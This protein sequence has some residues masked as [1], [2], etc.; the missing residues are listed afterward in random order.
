MIFLKNICEGTC[1]GPS[2]VFLFLLKF[3]K[4]WAIHL[5]ERSPKT[6][7]MKLVKASVIP[8]LTF[9]FFGKIA[10]QN[11]LLDGYVYENANRGYLN[12]VKI[13]AMRLSD[14]TIVGQTVSNQEGHFMLNVDNG[15]YRLSAEKDIFFLKYDTVRVENGKG[16]SKIEMK[17]KPGYLFDVTLAEKRVSEDQAVDAIQG[18]T[19]EIYN[20]TTKKSEMVLKNHPNPG[21]QFTFEQGNIYTIM[22]RKNGYLTRRIEANVAVEGCILCIDGVN[23][24]RP[25]MTENLTE[26]NS[27]GTLL[28]NLDMDKADMGRK[29]ELKNIY[30]DYDKWFIRKEAAKEL[31]KAVTLLKDNPS[32]KVELGSHTDS[33]G[34]TAYN[35]TLS[36]KRAESAVAYIVEHG[37]LQEKITAKGY[38]ESQL[39]NNCG[40][41][42]KC[43]EAEHQ[44]N[45]RT[46]LKITGVLDDPRLFVENQPSLEQIIREEEF[47]KS[48]KALSSEK[49]VKIT[50]KPAKS[51]KPAKPTKDKAQKTEVEMPSKPI[52]MGEI[53]VKTEAIDPNS[54]EKKVVSE[55]PAMAVIEEKTTVGASVNIGSLP[56]NFTG[57]GVEVL[58]SDLPIGGDH[59]VFTNFNKVFVQKDGEAMFNYFIGISND[60]ASSRNW[61]L[62]DAIKKFPDA[63]LVSFAEG[64]KD[65]IK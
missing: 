51:T 15:D 25:G 49:E 17:R 40:D 4:K 1:A 47:D 13:T 12:Q 43:S 33:R 60:L 5:P 41:G 58:R 28:A 20:K 18:A 65:Y 50:E 57:F 24:L 14:N 46:E 11:A 27:M 9:L 39:F 55:T 48:L 3:V 29:I 7:F 62:S 6:Y 53:V 26:G 34:S 44:L 21:F 19:I 38:G 59:P 22:I 35:E 54:G 56:A 10:A 16:F 45:R 61:Y 42:V 30:Y 31:D 2:D 8:I 23:E 63:R 37:V 36:Q 64:V 52:P 32:I